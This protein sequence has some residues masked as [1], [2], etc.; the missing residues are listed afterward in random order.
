MLLTWMCSPGRSALVQRARRSVSV[1]STQ[2][3][4]GEAIEA[5]WAGAP[6]VCGYV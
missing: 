1:K 6:W 4:D 5:V 2:R 3:K